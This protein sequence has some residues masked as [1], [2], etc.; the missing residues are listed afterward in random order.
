M[1]QLYYV[2]VSGQISDSR[3]EDLPLRFLI[4]DQEIPLRYAAYRLEFPE[5]VVAGITDKGGYT[6]P[7]SA[8]DR[9]AML[10]WHIDGVLTP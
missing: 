1:A 6:K 7:L 9:A 2:T 5:K 8:V 4:T 10:A 3:I